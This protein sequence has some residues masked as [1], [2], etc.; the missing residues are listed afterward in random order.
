MELIIIYIKYYFVYL[1]LIFNNNRNK[2][3]FVIIYYLDYYTFSN[4]S[5]TSQGQLPVI[6]MYF[7]GFSKEIYVYVFL[8]NLYHKKFGHPC[9]TAQNTLILL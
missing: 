5:N 3:R 9:S 4:P 1:I 2:S 6:S 7:C 8:V